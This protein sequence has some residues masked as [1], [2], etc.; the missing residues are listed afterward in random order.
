MYHIVPK[1]LRPAFPFPVR[2][3]H[4]REKLL[5]HHCPQ[6]AALGKPEEKRVTPPPHVRTFYKGPDRPGQDAEELRI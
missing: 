5:E 1:G 3:E 4:V 2:G 6:L